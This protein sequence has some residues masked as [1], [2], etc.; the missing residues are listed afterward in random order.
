MYACC[1]LASQCPFPS[2]RPIVPQSS[3]ARTALEQLAEQLGG[4]NASAG[5]TLLAQH[6]LGACPCVPAACAAPSTSAAAAAAAGGT[7]DQR[8][9]F[10]FAVRQLG[11][12]GKGWANRLQLD[13]HVR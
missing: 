1:A 6:L 2:P 5:R 11:L 7:A 13:V 4:G 8:P 12:Q 9:S 3:E 10:F